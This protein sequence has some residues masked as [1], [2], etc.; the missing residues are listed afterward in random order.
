MQD[1][2]TQPPQAVRG[3][4]VLKEEHIP[5]P[6]VLPGQRGETVLLQGY[7][8]GLELLI[9]CQQLGHRP[10]RIKHL[11]GEEIGH[12]AVLLQGPAQ[13]LEGTAAAHQLDAHPI[14]EFLHG[15]QLDQP[16]LG[17]I[18]YM[19]AAAGAAVRPGELHNPHLTGE[20]LLAPVADVLQL[21]GGGVCNF[22]RLVNLPEVP[23]GGLLQRGEL[24][25]GE[26]AVE[27]DGDHLRPQVEAYIL[28]APEIVGQPGDDVLPRVLLHQ[29]EPPVPVDDPGDLCSRLQGVAAGVDN[30]PVPAVDLQHLHLVEGPAGLQPPGVVGLAAPL[31]VEGGAVQNDVKPL[32]P[33]GA[34][35]DFCL[36]FDDKG[37]LFV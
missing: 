14:P 29:V 1:G 2:V 26:G 31:G 19:G 24:L 4:A 23:V 32:F 37:V 17:G 15:Q 36:E 8:P 11:G 33:L 22:Y 9:F 34:G 21:L 20:G 25:F 27:V 12:L 13:V 28:A 35:E 18:I 6:G 3:Q 7:D 10:R 30:L 5:G 16:H